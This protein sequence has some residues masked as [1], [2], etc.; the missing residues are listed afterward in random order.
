MTLEIGKQYA[1]AGD[2]NKRYEIV[3]IHGAMDVPPLYIIRL[4]GRIPV[5]VARPQYTLTQRMAIRELTELPAYN[6]VG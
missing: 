1:F 5:S 3:D 2:N 4:V 6:R